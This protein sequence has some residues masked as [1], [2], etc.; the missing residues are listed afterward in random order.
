M[1]R[2]TIGVL[3]LITL[4][5]CVAV[6]N[7]VASDL[8][9]LWMSLSSEGPAQ[10]DFPSGTETV[11]AVFEY[12]DFVQENVRVVVSDHQGTIVFEAT[13][14]FSGSGTASLPATYGQRAFPDGLYVTTLYFAGQY[15]TRA[16]EWTVGG[17]ELPATPTPQPPAQLEVEP[18]TLTF[19]AQQS[20]ANPPAQRVLVS[21]NTAAASVWRSTTPAPWLDLA[22]EGGETPALLRVSV[23]AAGL[24]AGAYTT[25]V[26]INA[27]D[28]ARSPQRVDIA[29]R[30]SAPAGTTTLDLPAVATGTGWVVSDEPF[31]NHFGAGDIRAGLQTDIEYLGGLEF[32]LSLIPAGSGIQAAAVILSGSRWETQPPAGDWVLELLDRGLAEEWSGLGYA[33]IAGPGSGTVLM[34]DYTVDNLGSGIESIWYLDTAG[35]G[36]LESLVGAGDTSVMRLRYEP[37][38]ASGPNAEI[39]DGLFVWDATAILRVNFEPDAGSAVTPTPD[40]ATE[41]P[42]AATATRTLP[43]VTSTATGTPAPATPTPTPPPIVPPPPPGGERPLGG[44]VAGPSWVVAL[45]GV[46]GIVVRQLRRGE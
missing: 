22:P 29:L 19:S 44:L 9:A 5:P 34:P 42:V 3:V 45:F 8:D 30:V 20:G 18:A 43:A 7:V 2:L 38:P 11:Y 13:Q 28:V 6:G 21:N 27:D 17:V 15:M 39:A 25:H 12:T 37:T 46:V 10:T 23:D 33:D 40:G 35:L 1:R 32:D 24:P 31:G 16:V 4:L 14:T 41:T 26:T 36:V